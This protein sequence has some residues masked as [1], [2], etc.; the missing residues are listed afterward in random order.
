MMFHINAIRR[1][2]IWL[3]FINNSNPYLEPKYVRSLGL[4]SYLFWKFNLWK[5]S[6]RRVSFRSD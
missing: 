6:I 2:L 3:Y 4:I 5:K 1:R